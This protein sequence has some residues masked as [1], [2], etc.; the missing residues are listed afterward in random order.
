MKNAVSLHGFSTVEN[1][2]YTLNR[3][4]D[5]QPLKAIL[6]AAVQPEAQP[7]RRSTSWIGSH[8]F[9]RFEIETDSEADANPRSSSGRRVYQRRSL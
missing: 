6:H 5:E 9:R 4:C 7:E 8:T 2:K 3:A 1:S